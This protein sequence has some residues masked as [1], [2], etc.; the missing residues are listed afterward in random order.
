MSK[1]EEQFEKGWKNLINFGYS[2]WK[3]DCDIS[4]NYKCIFAEKKTPTIAKRGAQSTIIEFD[5]AF[6]TESNGVFQ[7]ISIILTEEYEVRFFV[8]EIN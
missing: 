6:F 1:G 4:K 7:N 3:F 5:R 8:I 2:N